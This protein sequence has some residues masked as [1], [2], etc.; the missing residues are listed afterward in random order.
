MTGLNPDPLCTL[1]PCLKCGSRDT[2][3]RYCDACRHKYGSS[4]CMHGEAEHFHRGCRQCSYEWRTND[5][6]DPKVTC[7]R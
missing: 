7:N 6:M 5:V 3:M 4:L 2:W 1:D